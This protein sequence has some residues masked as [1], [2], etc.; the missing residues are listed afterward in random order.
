MLTMLLGL[1]ET[2]VLT[3]LHVGLQGAPIKNNPIEKNSVFQP[4]EY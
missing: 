3:K 4:W 2:C 1:T